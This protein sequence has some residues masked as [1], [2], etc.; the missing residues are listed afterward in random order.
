LVFADDCS[1][2]RMSCRI[3]VPVTEE[4]PLLKNG[5][6]RDLTAMYEKL[7]LWT[8]DNVDKNCGT[9]AHPWPWPPFVAVAQ[10]Q[11]PNF[12][13]NSSTNES[14]H[15]IVTKWSDV[16][17]KW[18]RKVKVFASLAFPFHTDE[19]LGNLPHHS[20][21]LGWWM[22][23]MM[24]MMMFDVHAVRSGSRYAPRHLSSSRLFNLSA[25]APIL[26]PLLAV[27]VAFARYS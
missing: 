27:A 14:T 11:S 5:M 24:M 18:Q 23:S 20:W 16:F 26:V 9:F 7:L 22:I 21:S 10:R 17:V 15:Y 25:T 2:E 4:F 13:T 3:N 1:L 12:L 8:I 6:T 19:K